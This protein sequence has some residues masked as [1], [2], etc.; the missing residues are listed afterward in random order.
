MAGHRHFFGRA[1]LEIP[2]R[3]GDLPG[4]DDVCVIDLPGMGRCSC[5]LLKDLDNG[6]RFAPSGAMALRTYPRL[7]RY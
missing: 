2:S 6:D 4:D 7:P 5:G 3:R 1:V